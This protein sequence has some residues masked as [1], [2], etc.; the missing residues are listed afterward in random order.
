[1]NVKYI[2]PVILTWNEEENIGRCLAC[3]DWAGEVVVVDSGST[4]RTL[5]IC[6]QSRNVRV[7]H[8]EFDSHANQANF[9][10]AQA[11][12]PWVLSL[13]ADYILPVDFLAALEAFDST[14]KTAARA[15]FTYCVFGKPL[16]GT[17]YPPR[18][19]LHR[20]QDVHY[21]QDGHTQR[22]VVTGETGSLAAKIYHDDRKPIGRWFAS[23][24]AYAAL[25]AGKLQEGGRLSLA[26]RIRKA[27]WLAPGLV[28]VWC[29]FVKGCFLD[30]RR[31]LYYTLQRL[32]AEVMLSLCLLDAR[33]KG[34][35]RR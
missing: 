23:Q 13:D 24:R 4:D 22:A 35:E 20:T 27:G 32:A 29:L 3:L 11:G 6:A 1:M 8:R 5:Q 19:V 26:D 10:M 12:T 14:D 18:F 25:E 15:S 17:L 34:E 9:A 7:V 21:V 33:L 2:T 30:G 16:R 28:V 31:G